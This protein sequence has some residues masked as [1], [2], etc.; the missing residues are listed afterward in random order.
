MARQYNRKIEDKQVMGG[1]VVEQC[2]GCD[3]VVNDHCTR[4]A[5]PKAIW[6]HMGCGLGG[7]HVQVMEEAGD[8]K[9]AK[10]VEKINP[11]KASKRASKGK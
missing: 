1:P 2:E 6:D 7:Q 4:Y 5:S 10:K 8:N 3:S 11:L 9:P